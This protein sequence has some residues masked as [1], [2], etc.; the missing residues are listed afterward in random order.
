MQL[1]TVLDRLVTPT[2]TSTCWSVTMPQVPLATTSTDDLTDLGSPV[3]NAVISMQI[4]KTISVVSF[5]L[6]LSQLCSFNIISPFQTT[7]KVLAWALT[8][9]LA[10]VYQR[11]ACSATPFRESK[12]PSSTSSAIANLR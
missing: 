9:T 7:L 4:V 3:L 8:H 2:T 6:S 5:S 12:A 10:F 1:L 11:G